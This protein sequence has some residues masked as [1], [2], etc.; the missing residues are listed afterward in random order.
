MI[1]QAASGYMWLMKEAIDPEGPPI[2]APEAPADT[3]PGFCALI[4]ILA[5]LIHRYKTGHGQHIDIAQMDAMIAVMQSFSFWNLAEITYIKAGSTGRL[6]LSGLYKAENNYIM[7]SLPE[8]RI[9]D[10]F[11]EL[12]AVEELTKEVVTNWVAERTVKEVI[13]KMA[14]IGVP[15]A[16]VLDLDQVQANEQVKAREMFVKVYHPAQGET[17]LPGFPIKFSDTKGDITTPAPMLGQHNEEIYSSLLALSETEI[18]E[19]RREGV[20]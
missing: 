5:A 13:E 1:A 14:E 19:K 10:R 15:A 7:F 18:E 11:R 17:T 20:I 4:G 8:G 9:T 2:H 3:I 6:R 12:L 16:P